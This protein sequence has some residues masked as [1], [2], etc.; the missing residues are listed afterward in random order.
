M[1]DNGSPYEILEKA[2]ETLD[3]DLLLQA[4]EAGADINLDTDRLCWGIFTML[5]PFVVEPEDDYTEET[6]RQWFLNRQRIITMLDVAIDHG[7]T[8]N[9]CYDDE[10][11]VHYPISS[12]LLYAPDDM[13]FVDWL[14]DKGFDPVNRYSD[15]SQF[16]ELVDI[17][18]DDIDDQNDH[19]RWLLK[20][21]LH[22]MDR[23]PELESQYDRRKLLAMKEKL[24]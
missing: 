13:E 5:E 24:K 16:D 21:C 18:E 3:P 23:F 20:L 7:L 15:C 1:E 4:I 14:I 8:M 11:G 17:L 19:C 6:Q 10:G 12:F 9:E 22:L 2:Y